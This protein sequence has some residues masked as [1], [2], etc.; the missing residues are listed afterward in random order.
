MKPYYNKRLFCFRGDWRAALEALP[1]PQSTRL[2]NAIASY[3]IYGSYDDS[4]PIVKSSMQVIIGSMKA[5]DRRYAASQANGRMG[6]RPTKEKIVAVLTDYLEPKFKSIAE[7]ACGYKISQST[8]RRYLNIAIFRSIKL[9]R[10][11]DEGF[12]LRIAYYK[13]HPYSKKY[14]KYE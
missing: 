12:L 8:V 3:G 13:H 14:K 11:K 7:I 2:L 10:W 5:T 1:E 4:D 9:G 6:G